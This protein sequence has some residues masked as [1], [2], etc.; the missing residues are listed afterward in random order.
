MPVGHN[1][2]KCNLP[3]DKCPCCGADDETFHHL[4]QCENEQIASVRKDILPHFRIYCSELKIPDNFTDFFA[5]VIF[6]ALGIG[7]A[8]APNNDY[9]AAAYKSQKVIG[10]RN[11]MVGFLST[12]WEEALHS[13]GIDN[14]ETKME[15]ILRFLWDSICE[16]IWFIRNEI[17]HS[18][19]S[20]VSTDDMVTLDD[21]LRWYLRHQARILDYRHRFLVDYDVDVIASWSR[22]TRQQKITLL[23]NARKWYAKRCEIRAR[24]QS[25]MHD[26]MDK[27]TRLRNGK[28]VGKGIANAISTLPPSDGYSSDESEEYEF[29]WDQSSG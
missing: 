25:T 27:Y 7:T 15:A 19:E 12:G 10:F 23:D 1:W 13:F 22:S 3:S 26:W 9:L 2:Q 28:L 5:K 4:L 11:F 17:H 14:S 29:D 6:E 21:R 16:P 24:N 20:C 8:P 18:K